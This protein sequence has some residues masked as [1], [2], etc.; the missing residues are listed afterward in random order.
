MRRFYFI[1]L[2][3]VLLAACSEQPKH[4]TWAAVVSIAPHSNPKWNPDEVVVTVR[5]EEGAM[6]S[7]SVLTARLKCRVG[8]TV[9]GTAQ[10]LA[11][12]LDNHACKR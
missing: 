4:E 6:G 5:S 11:F 8:D 12:T 7:K 10:G 9:H 3:T 1:L 2:A